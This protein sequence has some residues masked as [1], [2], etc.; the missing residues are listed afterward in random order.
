MATPK[1]QL[2]ADSPQGLYVAFAPLQD[3]VKDGARITCCNRCGK[4]VGHWPRDSFGHEIV[5]LNCAADVPQIREHIDSLAKER[6][7]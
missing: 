6:G 1:I 5:C 3:R 7:A 2:P 4:L